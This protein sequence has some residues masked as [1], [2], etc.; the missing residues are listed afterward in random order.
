MFNL[1]KCF[2]HSNRFSIIHRTVCHILDISYS[3]SGANTYNSLFQGVAYI[4]SIMALK[5]IELLFTLCTQL[6][7]DSKDRKKR[8]LNWQ[9]CTIYTD[10]Q[11]G[12]LEYIVSGWTFPKYLISA[13][14]VSL[15]GGL[16]CTWINKVLQWNK[17]Q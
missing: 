12:E 4:V 16:P 3:S 8:L 9:H 7:M 17:G 2:F 13:S 15:P 6:A 11:F 1:M 5:Y 10:C 14:D